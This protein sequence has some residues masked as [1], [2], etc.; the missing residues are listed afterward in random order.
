MFMGA[1]E[2]AKSDRTKARE[3]FFFDFAKA[4][5]SRFPNLPLIVT[6]GFR[7]RLGME[8]ALTKGG[9]DMVGVGRPAALNPHLPRNIVLNKEIKDED[10]K[11]YAKKVEMPWLARQAPPAIGAGAESVSSYPPPPFSSCL[12]AHAGG[13][14]R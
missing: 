6:G 7:T 4:I 1:K 14:D 5:R 8:S 3:A 10:A 12:V 2:S 11:L 9:C 13:N